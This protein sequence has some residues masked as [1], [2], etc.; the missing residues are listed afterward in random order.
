MDVFPVVLNFLIDHESEEPYLDFKEILN[1]DE[2]GPFGDIA[3]DMLPLAISLYLRT[4]FL[5]QAL[6]RDTGGNDPEK[7]PDLSSSTTDY[8]NLTI[9]ELER[10][11]AMIMDELDSRKAKLSEQI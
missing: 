10:T 7:R 1:I 6:A 3:K 8:E 2:T 5:S 4:W 11:A 9:A